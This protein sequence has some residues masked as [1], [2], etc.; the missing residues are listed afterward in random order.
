MRVLCAV[1]EPL[2]PPVLRPWHYVSYGGWVAGQF[3]RDDYPWRIPAPLHQTTQKALGRCLVPALLHQDIEHHPLL[4]HRSPQPVLTPIA[5][6]LHLVNVPRVARSRTASPQSI[7]EDLPELMTPPA[8]GLKT[9]RNPPLRQQ[10]L[11]I[12]IALNRNR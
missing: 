7:R 9:H 8:D 3:V 10:L 2:V 4:I 11:H 6:E 5:L 1:V 12:P